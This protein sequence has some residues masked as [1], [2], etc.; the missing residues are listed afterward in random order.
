MKK[1][2][3]SV[4][5]ACVATAGFAQSA[6]PYLLY[7]DV[8]LLKDGTSVKGH[9]IEK[10]PERSLKLQTQE[11]NT[12]AYRMSEIEKITKEVVI[13]DVKPSK[14]GIAGTVDFGYNL[15]IGKYAANRFSLNLGIGYQTNSYFYI[16]GGVGVRYFP[17]LIGMESQVPDYCFPVFAHFRTT[18]SDSEPSLYCSVDIGYSLP[19][20]GFMLNPTIGLDIKRNNQSFF[21]VGAGYEM[22]KMDLMNLVD[23]RVTS[24]NFG[25]IVI[26]MGFFL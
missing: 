14:S 3:L 18:F 19:K 13:G 10:I 11:G 21:F 26:K 6:Y 9:I 20:G 25:A 5:F 7:S 24:E 8:V 4:L 12:Y 2:L 15:G 1:A 23:Y 22:Q 17:K 16:G